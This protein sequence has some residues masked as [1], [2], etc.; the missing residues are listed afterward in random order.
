MGPL[1]RREDAD[2]KEEGKSKKMR[3]SRRWIRMRI[4]KRRREGRVEIKEDEK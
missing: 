4:R 3:N 2:E 1:V